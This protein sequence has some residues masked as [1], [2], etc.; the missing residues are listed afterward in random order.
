MSLSM[1]I[2]SRRVHSAVVGLSLWWCE[3]QEDLYLFGTYITPAIALWYEV[4]T[5]LLNCVYVSAHDATT[6]NAQLTVIDEQMNHHC[7]QSKDSNLNFGFNLF[8]PFFVQNS[9]DSTITNSFKS[10]L[11]SPVLRACNSIRN[12]PYVPYYTL[13]HILKYKSPFN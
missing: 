13:F 12:D 6:E 11:D 5:L 3:F 9:F 8:F 7:C 2:C 10:I 1:S 4:S